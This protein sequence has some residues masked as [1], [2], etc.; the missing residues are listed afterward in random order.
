VAHRP[1]AELPDRDYPL[2]FTTKRYKEHYNSGAQ[3]RR[4]PELIDAQ[5]SPRLELHP[6][7]AARIGVRDG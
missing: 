7:L 3:T 5:P 6:W 4:V 1:A 2:L